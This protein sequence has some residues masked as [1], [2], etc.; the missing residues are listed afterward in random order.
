M[1]QS[2]FVEHCGDSIGDR[3]KLGLCKILE[4]LEDYEA[5]AEKYLE[6]VR[7]PP[8]W[9]QHTN[10]FTAVVYRIMS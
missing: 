4:D 8:L 7:E 3:Q 10:V 9:D 5:A 1:A 6:N 2:H